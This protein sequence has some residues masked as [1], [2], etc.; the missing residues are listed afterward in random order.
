[1]SATK[2]QIVRALLVSE[3][4]QYGMVSRAEG[5]CAQWFTGMI[6][7]VLDAL[8][9]L[10]DATPLPRARESVYDALIDALVFSVAE[11]VNAS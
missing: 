9:E 6:R 10:D 11:D 7:D 5:E 3:E 1:M 2:E 4:R 8:T